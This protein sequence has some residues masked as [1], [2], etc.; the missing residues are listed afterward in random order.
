MSSSL[1]RFAARLAVTAVVFAC[2]SCQGG[3]K[4]YPVR[5]SVFVNGKPGDGVTVVFHARN[6]SD[7]QPAQP[8]AIVGPDGSFE[9]KTWL[10]DKRVL[11]EGAPAGQYH[12][13]C[14]WYPPDLQRFLN[15][16][17]PLPDKLNGKY[18]VP[19]TSG[20]NA[21]VQEHA[22]ELARYEL[23]TGKK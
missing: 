13:T 2:A 20:L 1:S 5:G 4:F 12:V 6:D 16:G 3:K 19:K 7:P 8:T 10:V 18:A 11:K 17:A 9:L 22:N 14:I 21:T 23:E 15:A